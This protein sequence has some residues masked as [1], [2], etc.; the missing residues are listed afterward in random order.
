MVIRIVDLLWNSKIEALVSGKGEAFLKTNR[1]SL[2]IVND[3]G[4]SFVLIIG[5]ALVGGRNLGINYASIDQ[6]C[7]TA[8]SSP[9]DLLRVLADHLGY[10]VKKREQ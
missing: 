9:E 6:Q 8:P 5:N 1:I 3:Q 7:I 4:K 10:E 2:D